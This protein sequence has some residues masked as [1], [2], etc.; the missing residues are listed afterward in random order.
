MPTAFTPDVVEARR[1][2][3]RE[4]YP[5]GDLPTLAKQLGIS[6]HRLQTLASRL[7]VHRTAE[8][9][10]RIRCST[11]RMLP[12]GTEIR[13]LLAK[14]ADRPNGVSSGEVAEALEVPSSTV[15][16]A[17]SSMQRGGKLHPATISHRRVRYFGTAEAAADFLR[18]L[19]AAGRRTSTSSAP[20]VVVKRGPGPAYLPGEPVETPSTKYTI[21]PPPKAALRSNTFLF[22]A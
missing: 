5:T 16:G 6:V 10:S 13:A 15:W 12:R 17:V 22:S 20:T 21:A 3:I 1:A 14:L 11:S 18:R 4:R 7:G 2:L 19:G 9:I 8:T